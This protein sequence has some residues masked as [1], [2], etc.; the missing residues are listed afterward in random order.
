MNRKAFTLIELLVVVAII[1]ILAAV[2]VVAYNGYTKSAK[3]AVT[4]KLHQNFLSWVKA[5]YTKCVIDDSI[6]IKLT[7]SSGNPE[8]VP[9][10]RLSQ[11]KGGGY[12][13]HTNLIYWHWRLGVDAKN[14]WGHKRDPGTVAENDAYLQHSSM[15]WFKKNLNNITA[16]SPGA[17]V[18]FG[19]YECSGTT[20]CELCSYDGVKLMCDNF[21]LYPE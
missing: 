12:T 5:E 9:C 18:G 13:N 7:S 19:N 10:D 6:S 15:T 16:A 20:N 21:S 11:N 1:G 4:K 3:I 2:G 8:D 17:L 14:A